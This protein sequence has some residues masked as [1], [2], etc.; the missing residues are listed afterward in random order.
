MVHT[1]DYYAYADGSCSVTEYY[2]QGT[3]LVSPPFFLRHCMHGGKN[4]VW[5]ALFETEYLWLFVQSLI[6]AP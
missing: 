2:K 4:L 3:F 6:I 1:T 5:F